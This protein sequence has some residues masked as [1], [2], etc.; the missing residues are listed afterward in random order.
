MR[1]HP[2]FTWVRAPYRTSVMSPPWAVAVNMVAASGALTPA[3]RRRLYNAVGLDVGD[4]LIYP[5]C[6]FH[7]ADISNGA[8]VVI[9]HGCHFENV[10]PISI[11]PQTGIAP[12]T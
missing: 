2:L 11:G 9:N 6:Y 10:A 5:R 12:L 1:R 4:A 7:T 8:G 3:A